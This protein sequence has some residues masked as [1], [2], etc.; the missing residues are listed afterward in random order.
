MKFI[1]VTFQNTNVIFGIIYQAFKKYLDD[2][3]FYCVKLTN[4]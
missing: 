1:E 4:I 2:I 3:F